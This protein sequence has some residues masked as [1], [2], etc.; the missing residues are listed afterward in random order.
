MLKMIFLE[1]IDIFYGS[2]EVQWT[3]FS[4]VKI[5][6]NT[7]D[8]VNT[9]LFPYFFDK[10]KIINITSSL[11]QYHLILHILHNTF[12]YSNKTHLVCTHGHHFALQLRY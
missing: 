3:I 8:E 6:E 4:V 7:T 11:S 10:Q 2:A 12:L 1:S 5:F 9:L